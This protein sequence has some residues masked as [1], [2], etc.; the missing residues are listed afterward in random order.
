MTDSHHRQGAVGG[1][2]LPYNVVGK[3]VTENPNEF[4]KFVNNPQTTIQEACRLGTL[5]ALQDAGL[6]PPKSDWEKSISGSVTEPTPW[7]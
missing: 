7:R 2:A 3:F 5:A 6:Y 1:G 4:Q